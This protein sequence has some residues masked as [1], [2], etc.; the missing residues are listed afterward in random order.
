VTF[1]DCYPLSRL[2]DW[3]LRHTLIFP[4]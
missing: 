1:T 4:V 2:N 3:L